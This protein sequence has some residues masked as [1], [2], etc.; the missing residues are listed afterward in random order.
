MSIFGTNGLNVFGTNGLNAIGTNGLHVLIGAT[1]PIPAAT[2]PAHIADDATHDKLD[3][4]ITLNA[5]T[6]I[7][8]WS[9][10]GLVVYKT[11]FAKRHV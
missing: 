6:V 4:Q 7:A 5:L 11:F 9:T 2:P 10:L 1:E 3:T 8:A